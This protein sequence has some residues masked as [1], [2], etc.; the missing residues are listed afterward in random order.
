MKKEG[1]KI[2]GGRPDLIA[3]IAPQKRFAIETKGYSHCRCGNMNNH[4]KQAQSGPL[5]VDFCVACVS[6]NIYTQIEVKYHDPENELEYD[7]NRKGDRDVFKELTK[8]YY[9]GLVSFLKLPYDIVSYGNEKFYEI[10]FSYFFREIYCSWFCHCFL[11]YRY[12]I[13]LSTKIDSWA[14]EGLTKEISP[15]VHHQNENIYI[16]NDGVGIKFEDF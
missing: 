2:K 14:Q 12:K 7:G 5:K 6:Y 3:Y 8:K 10:N 4:K 13:L 16:D 11:K 9:S 1:Y 15:F